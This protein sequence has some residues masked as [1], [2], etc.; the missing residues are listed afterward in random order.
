MQVLTI[1]SITS[2]TSASVCFSRSSKS[3]ESQIMPYLMTSPIPSAKISSESVES[4]SL[5]Q[6]TSAGCLK[7]PTRFFPPEISTAV[8][9]PTD[10]STCA[11]SVVGIWIKSIPLRKQAAANPVISPTTPPPSAMMKSLRVMFCSQRKSKISLSVLMHFDCSPCGKT[12]ASHSKPPA[13]K[14]F[15]TSSRYSFATVSSVIITVFRDDT[16]SEI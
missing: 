13:R 6:S 15:S 2:F 5:S 14:D 1:S 11:R 4:V 8:F 10:E 7:A 12:K 9:P 16:T 3:F